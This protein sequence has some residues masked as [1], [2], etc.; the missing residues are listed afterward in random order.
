MCCYTRAIVIDQCERDPYFLEGLL[1]ELKPMRG[2]GFTKPAESRNVVIAAI[3]E[4]LK[5]HPPQ[6]I[7]ETIS[8]TCKVGIDH[9]KRLYYAEKKINT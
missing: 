2:P 3:I 5:D 6:D 8:I 4:N 9:A 7:W 1:K